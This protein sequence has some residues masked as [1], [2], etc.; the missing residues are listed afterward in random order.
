LC[1]LVVKSIAVDTRRGPEVTPMAE[2][3]MQTITESPHKIKVRRGV[4]NRGAQPPHITEVGI[5][6]LA[7]ESPWLMPDGRDHS[8]LLGH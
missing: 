6:P 8:R 1:L 3:P 2:Q 5:Y 7:G 4:K